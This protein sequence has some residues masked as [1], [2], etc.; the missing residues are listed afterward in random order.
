MSAMNFCYGFIYSCLYRDVTSMRFNVKQILNEIAIMIGRQWRP[1]CDFSSLSFFAISRGS[2][3]YLTQEEERAG[4]RSNL[5][6]GQTYSTS[7][8]SFVS[9]LFNLHPAHLSTRFNL[10]CPSLQQFLLPWLADLTR[11]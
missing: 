5:E 3:G 9:N 1:V 6:V 10:I 11:S 2:A 8:G 7:L 4:S